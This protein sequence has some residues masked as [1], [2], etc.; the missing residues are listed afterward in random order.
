MNPALRQGV[1]NEAMGEAPVILQDG[2][3]PV[4]DDTYEIDGVLVEEAKLVPVGYQK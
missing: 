4:A 2:D 1:I 3:T